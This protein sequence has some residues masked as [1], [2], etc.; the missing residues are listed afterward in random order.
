MNMNQLTAALRVL[1][2]K[3]KTLTNFYSE[4]QK[5]GLDISDRIVTEF[6]TDALIA[7]IS[8]MS[9]NSTKVQDRVQN[10]IYWWLYD[11]PKGPSSVIFET[12]IKIVVDD[13]P[14]SLA[15][16]IIFSMEYFNK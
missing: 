1:K 14:E 2:E 11:K 4:L 15:R 16:M 3:E 6:G 5:V 10:D 12:E 9:S 13:T 7:C 8:L